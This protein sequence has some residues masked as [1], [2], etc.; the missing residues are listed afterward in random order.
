M[1]QPTSR[2][3]RALQAGDSANLVAE[4]NV[5]IAHAVSDGQDDDAL[6]TAAREI[7]S[8][9]QAEVNPRRVFCGSTPLATALAATLRTLAQCACRGED[10]GAM[11]RSNDALRANAQRAEAMVSSLQSKKDRMAEKRIDSL[12]QQQLRYNTSVAKENCA[13]LRHWHNPNP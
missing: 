5:V 1:A 11:Q 2:A 7:R 10:G 8:I 6:L 4:L 12:F 3:A 9:L 13:K